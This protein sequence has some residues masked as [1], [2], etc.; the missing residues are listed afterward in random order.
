VHRFRYRKDRFR[1]DP[2]LQFVEGET[3]AQ[4]AARNGLLRVWDAGKTRWELTV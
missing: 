2:D 3:E 4:L 1:R